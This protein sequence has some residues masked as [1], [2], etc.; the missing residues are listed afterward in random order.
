MTPA[1]VAGTSQSRLRN[2]SQ[3]VPPWVSPVAVWIVFLFY[4]ARFFHLISHWAVNIFFWDEWDVTNATLFQHHS[5]WEIFT[6]Q[7][8]PQREGLGGVFAALVEPL[9]RWNSRTESFLVGGII[10]L[11]AFLAVFLK[12]RL[13]G[14]LTLLDTVIA[15]L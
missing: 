14:S 2:I 3:R 8:G 9:F 10:A 4:A 11:T 1:S 15:V 12:H 7:I 5:L 13:Y 6:W